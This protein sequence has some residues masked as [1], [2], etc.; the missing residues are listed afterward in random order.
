[1]FQLFSE[2]LSFLFT[3]PDILDPAVITCARTSGAWEGERFNYEDVSQRAMDRF[4]LA[5]FAYWFDGFKASS[6]S[7]ALWN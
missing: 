2:L 5:Y 1:M 3:K 6:E 7:R 4:G